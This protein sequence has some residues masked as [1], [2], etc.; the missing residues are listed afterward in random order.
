VCS[1]FS[2]GPFTVLARNVE[3]ASAVSSRSKVGIGVELANHLSIERVPTLRR[4]PAFSIEKG[5]NIG[6]GEPLPAEIVDSYQQIF[7]VLSL[8]RWQWV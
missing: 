4:L 2:N 6:G 3:L 5:G 8:S 1:E 7:V